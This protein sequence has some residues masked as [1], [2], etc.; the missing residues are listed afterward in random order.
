[1]RILD[2]DLDFFL[3][4]IAHD[5][6][7]GGA[8]LSEED[9][10]PWASDKVREF[11]EKNCGLSTQRRIPGKYITHHHEAFYWWRD[12][13]RDG[14]LAKPFEVVHVD[15]HA[16]L[17][18]GTFAHSMVYV[19]FDLLHQPLEKRES[20]EE[21]DRKMN[22]GNYLLVAIACRWLNRL[23]YVMHRDNRLKDCEDWLFSDCGD[24]S[25]TLALPKLEKP[26]IAIPGVPP[27]VIELEPGVEFVPASENTF[28]DDGSFDYFVLC[29]SPGFTPKSSDL[30]V[31]LI[32]EYMAL[33]H[34]DS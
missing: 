11:L 9:F 8:R 13:I 21:G 18:A 33:S 27:K 23:V 12:L 31:P 25:W 5:Q 3:S 22:A 15:A 29:R 7:S 20:P 4:S 17:G 28:R 32:Q 14:K 34:D 16:D 24:E 30:L 26:K 6:S 2:L 1:M 10:K 19:G